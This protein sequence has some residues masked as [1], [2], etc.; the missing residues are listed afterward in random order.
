MLH[1]SPDDEITLEECSPRAI[2]VANNLMTLGALQAIRE[3]GVHIP[4]EIAL[5]GFDDMP[6]SSELCPPLTAVS[7]PTYQIGQEAVHL[8]L[9]RLADPA[10]QFRTVTLQTELVVRESCGASRQR[11]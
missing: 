4:E 8:L 3:V 6:W 1:I 9:R 5:V 7:Q 2:F 10:A 11:V